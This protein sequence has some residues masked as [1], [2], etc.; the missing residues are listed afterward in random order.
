VP[1]RILRPAAVAEKLAVCR[2]TF[3]R[4]T[5]RPDF[6]RAVRLSPGAVGFVEE[7]IDDWIER[8]RQPQP[9]DEPCVRG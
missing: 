1:I 2:A 3:W 5:K 8:Q 7:E 4:Y 6:P 9:E